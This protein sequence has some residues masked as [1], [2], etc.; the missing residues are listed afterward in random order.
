MFSR[1]PKPRVLAMKYNNICNLW[2]YQLK[3]VP[4]DLDLVISNSLM[5][6]TQDDYVI[7]M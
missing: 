5:L 2:R 1:M 3:S 4:F 6:L 7:V